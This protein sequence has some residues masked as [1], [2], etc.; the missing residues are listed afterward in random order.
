MAAK[1]PVKAFEVKAPV[2]GIDLGT[3][4]SSVAV[5]RGGKPE[6][7]ANAQGTHS[8][9]S[10]VGFL[11]GELLVG[12]VACNNAPKNPT[13][14]VVDC[15]RMFGRKA[16][17]LAA[18]AK[19]WKCALTQKDGKIAVQVVHKGQNTAFTAEQI[20]GHIISNL[21][22]TA[23]S[24]VHAGVKN[25]VLTAPAYFDDSQRAAL[26]EAAGHAGITVLRVISE[27]VAAAIA[28]DLD[29]PNP[30]NPFSTFAVFNIGSRS[31]EVVVLD[32]KGGIFSERGAAVDHSFGGDC[33]DDVLLKWCAEQF[34]KKHKMDPSETSRS[35]ARLR[36]GCERAK[37]QLTLIS[38]TKIEVESAHEGID[39][40]VSI[41]RA[42]FDELTS[43]VTAKAT[44]VVEAA[45]ANAKVTA[46][47]LAQMLLVGASSRIP[48]VQA[49]LQAALPGVELQTAIAP[50]EAAVMGAALQ[51]EALIGHR[52]TPSAACQ[53]SA[54]V[55]STP[56]DICIGCGP[57]VDTMLLA[58]AGTPLPLDL[59]F[60]IE[61]Q[62]AGQASML[63]EMYEG[64][65]GP[66]A[67]AQLVAAEC[68]HGIELGP[69]TAHLNI[70]EAGRLTLHA[71][72]ASGASRHN[73][74]VGPHEED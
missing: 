20:G 71:K 66:Q 72:D 57:G 41:S 65:P 10:V 48:R 59:S 9:P 30:L 11:D 3:H 23:E 1:A 58:P 18:D 55:P 7:V 42:K 29:Q 8:T 63:I 50:E 22:Q 13:N 67:S 53:I 73:I 31:C 74:V 28:Y 68:L 38:S 64:P 51:A 15:K 24:Y 2:V 69:I 39:F 56:R 60:S 32:V 61:L 62:E 37:K 16:E 33:I 49:L 6:A 5:V 12:D 70:D 46:A 27:P 44:S 36:V 34:K 26:V 4:S 25:A 52:V 35:M 47:D 40:S 19:R 17:D 54:Q 43:S 45:L 14:T 21:K